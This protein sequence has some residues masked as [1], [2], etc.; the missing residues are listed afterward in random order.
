[1]RRCLNLWTDVD[2]YRTICLIMVSISRC[3]SEA[4]EPQSAA[5]QLLLKAIQHQLRLIRRLEYT[6][7]L[8]SLYP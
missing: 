1:M 6:Y 7:L 5:C 8:T 4:P 3:L 2:L